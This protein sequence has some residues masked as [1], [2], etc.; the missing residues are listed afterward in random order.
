VTTAAAHNVSTHAQELAEENA[1][2]AARLREL[3][4]LLQL[5]RSRNKGLER[6]LSSLSERVVTLRRQSHTAPAAR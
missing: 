4:H 6:G 3:E 1:R 5:E 2:L